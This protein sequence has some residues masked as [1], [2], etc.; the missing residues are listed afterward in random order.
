M[1]KTATG[2]TQWN[3]MASSE[4][5]I[6]LSISDKT[7]YSN[8]AEGKLALGKTR[9]TS[10]F[11]I[12]TNKYVKKEGQIMEVT[13]YE[14]SI[15]KTQNG[16]VNTGLTMDEAIS[17]TAGHEAEHAT[18]EENIQNA[19]DNQSLPEF[20]QNDVESLPNEIGSKIRSEI[21]NTPKKIEPKPAQ[22]YKEEEMP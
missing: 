21:R 20:L 8:K 6:S 18:N 11:D 12:N 15:K 16:G 5:K 17:A 2:R 9:I 10:T 19:I 22:V 3:K 4:N 13:I 1:A 7:A 14:G